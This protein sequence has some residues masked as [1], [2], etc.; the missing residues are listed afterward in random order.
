MNRLLV[1]ATALSMTCSVQ[2]LAQ[3][4]PAFNQSAAYTEQI[5]S[6]RPYRIL[7]TLSA[8]TA[9]TSRNLPGVTTGS[10]YLIY[11]MKTVEVQDKKT[12]SALSYTIV[13][14]HAYGWK[15]ESKA[16]GDMICA[17]SGADRGA[18]VSVDYKSQDGVRFKAVVKLL[19]ELCPN[20]PYNREG[21]TIKTRLWAK[22]ANHRFL[23][24][25]RN[26]AS[27]VVSGQQAERPLASALT[28][29]GLS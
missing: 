4:M 17:V 7:Y 23:D 21:V 14:D 15:V 20:V 2:G 11:Q 28:P 3:S 26:S 1:A 16:G 19:V 10:F 9:Y 18:P 8:T 6:T 29:P 25:Y 13:D 5:L 27:G 22:D 24:V 12:L